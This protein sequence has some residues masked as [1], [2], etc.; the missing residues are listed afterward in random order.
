MTITLIVTPA[1]RQIVSAVLALVCS[2]LAIGA[3]ATPLFA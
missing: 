1:G 2:S 3:A